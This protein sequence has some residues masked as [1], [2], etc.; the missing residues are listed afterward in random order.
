MA[1][2]AKANL[3]R[4]TEDYLEAIL[5]LECEVGF[6]RAR[7]IAERLGV[8]RSA[9]SNALHALARS[10]LVDYKPYRM[11]KL[12]AKGRQAAVGVRHRH[13]ELKAFVTDVLGLDETTADEAAC[14]L[15]HRIDPAVL[16]RLTDLGAFILAT[17]AEDQTQWLDEFVQFCRAR[18]AAADAAA[19]A[20][21][22]AAAEAAADKRKAPHLG[23]QDM[24]DPENA[25]TLADVKPG[26]TVRVVRVSGATKT[27][28]RLVDMGLTRNAIVSV[29]RVAP[30]GD[31]VEIRVRGYNL[32]LGKEQAQGVLVEDV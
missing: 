5:A 16:Q 3:T 23:H 24:Q 7:D 4:A 30:L 20:A 17:R 31:P 11:V 10:A 14:R 26:G 8:G 27:D 1:K 28:R 21:T 19:D 13:A 29:V 15:E 6:A 2:A 12:T 25:F 18:N 22:D 32:S 9:V